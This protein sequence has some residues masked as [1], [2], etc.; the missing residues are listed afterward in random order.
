MAFALSVNL[1]KIALLRNSRP[2]NYPDVVAH[3]SRCLAAGADGLTV[4]PRPDQRHIRPDDVRQ[5][6]RLVAA[7]PGIEF[8]VEGNPFAQKLGNFPGF[9]ELVTETRPHQC[10]LVPD[11]NEQLTSDHGFDLTTAGN[12]LAPVIRQLKD[13][14]IRVSLFMDPDLAQISLARDIGADRIEL[15]TGPYAAACRRRAANLDDL[16]Q[17]YCRAATH[18]TRIGLGVNAGHDLDLDNLPK[19]A[20]L[21]GLLEVSIGHAL[22]VDALAL[23]LEDAVRAYKKCCS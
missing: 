19:F 9:L 4:H 22:I 6:A 8:N 21:P 20:G 16:F 10:T 15:Y 14:G 23:G 18:A 17:D 12:R 7:N 5:L 13:Q 11:S 3:G 1:N 2:G